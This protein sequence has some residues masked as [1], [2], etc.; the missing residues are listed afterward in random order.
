MYVLYNSTAR[1]LIANKKLYSCWLLAPVS[2]LV[3]RL[4]GLV[5]YNLAMSSTDMVG[6]KDS[7]E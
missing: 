6:I 3:P 5:G 4:P 2:L 1:D 7:I